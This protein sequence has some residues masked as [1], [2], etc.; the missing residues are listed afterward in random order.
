[1]LSPPGSQAGRAAGCLW[2]PSRR[3]PASEEAQA[4]RSPNHLMT[5]EGRGAR[6]PVRPLGLSW[7]SVGQENQSCG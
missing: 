5:K 1:M 3:P 6:S 7:T 2:D 4:K